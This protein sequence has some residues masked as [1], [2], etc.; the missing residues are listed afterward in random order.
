MKHVTKRT[1][2]YVS[3]VA[4]AVSLIAVT[5]A[6]ASK[7]HGAGPCGATCD[8]SH[9]PSMSSMPGMSSMPDMS[10]MPSPA[11]IP[12]NAGTMDGQM[13]S[14]RMNDHMVLTPSMPEHASD[15][16]RAASIVATLKAAI[17]KYQ[18]YRVAEQDGFKPFLARI[19]QPQYHFTNWRNAMQAETAFDPAKPTSLLYEKTSTG[20][21]LI[22]AMYTAPRSSTLAQL[23]SRVPLS[24]AHWHEHVNFCKG[25]PGTP[26]SAYLGPQARFGLEGSIVDADACVAAGGTFSP[27]IYNWMVHVYPY[28]TNAADVWKVTH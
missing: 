9:A 12:S 19:P 6:A 4:A 25:P 17:A 10:P 21:R 20:Y 11:R 13:G 26:L 27:V 15:Q 3:F 8:M 2:V 1:I 14:M 7:A 16:Q 18:D 22:G 5:G 28:A 23:D 24:V